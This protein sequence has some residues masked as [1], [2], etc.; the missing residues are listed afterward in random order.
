MEITGEDLEEDGFKSALLETV[1]KTLLVL[2]DLL[3]GFEMQVSHEIVDHLVDFVLKFLVSER[4]IGSEPARELETEALVFL[5]E[6]LNEKVVLLQ[7]GHVGVG[8]DDWA[9]NIKLSLFLSR[10]RKSTN[11]LDAGVFLLHLD[12][13]APQKVNLKI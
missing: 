10:I 2:E 12:S 13:T 5:A 1:G 4:P 6:L 3:F 7:A 9:G 8:D 11:L